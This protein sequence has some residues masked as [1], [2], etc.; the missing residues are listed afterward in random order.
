MLSNFFFSGVPPYTGVRQYWDDYSVHH[1]PYCMYFIPLNSLFPVPVSIVA[2]APFILFSISSGPMGYLCY[3][4]F[5]LGICILG[6][7]PVLLHSVL[8]HFSFH[9]LFW[10]LRILLLRIECGICLPYGWWY[11]VFLAVCPGRGGW[12]RYRPSTFVRPGRYLFLFCI[13]GFF[14]LVL[15]LLHR[16]GLNILSL[17][18][19]LFVW[20][21]LWCWSSLLV[22][23]SSGFWRLG[24]A[25]YSIAPSQT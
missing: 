13:L 22:H 23:I 11:L 10:L 19:P 8:E 21:C 18:V 3:L 15:W 9:F 7:L 1:L 24:W 20:C 5:L 12:D 16:S 4:W 6:L 25:K 17:T 2:V 14:A